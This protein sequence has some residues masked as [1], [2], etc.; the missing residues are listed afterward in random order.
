M[1]IGENRSIIVSIGRIREN[2]D[3]LHK[4]YKRINIANF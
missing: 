2:L 1:R 3:I 4:L